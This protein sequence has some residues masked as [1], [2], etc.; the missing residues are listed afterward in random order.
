[1]PAKVFVYIATSL[2]G[3]IAREHGELDWLDDAN[4]IVPQGEDCGYK[5]FFASMDVLVMGR[6]SYEKVLSFGNWPYGQTQVVVLSRRPITFPEELPAT[7]SHSSAPPRVLYN[8]LS[9]EG[10]RH[11]YVDGGQ[12]IQAFLA[13]RLVDEITITVI[14]II[15]GQGVPLFGRLDNDVPLTHIQTQAF[16][17]GFVQMK[18]AVGDRLTK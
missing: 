11:I 15:L 4:A 14:P 7:V 1:M 13:E 9:N 18:Y 2:D 12:T 5:D 8:R 10:A 16:D 6:K 3:F 17:F